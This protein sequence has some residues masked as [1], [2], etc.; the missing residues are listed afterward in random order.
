MKATVLPVEE[1]ARRWSCDRGAMIADQ[2]ETKLWRAYWHGEIQFVF[3]APDTQVAHKQNG[4]RI[5]SDKYDPIPAEFL[6][7]GVLKDRFRS[8]EYLRA[9]TADEIKIRTRERGYRAYI[10]GAGLEKSELQRWCEAKG[11]TPPSFWGRRRGKPKGAGKVDRSKE[12]AE[13][14]QLIK[15]GYTP[16]AASEEIG[17]RRF[18]NDSGTAAATF[19]RNLRRDYEKVGQKSD[20][21]D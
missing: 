21:S 13:M 8:V 20:M 1:I 16:N 15:S 18:P 2:I 7:S 4:V 3:R 11:H 9:C 17:R 10:D 6:F 5:P 12:L 14:I 19:A